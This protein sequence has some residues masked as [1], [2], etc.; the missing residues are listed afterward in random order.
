[1]FWTYIQEW[2]WALLPQVTVRSLEI[3][4]QLRAFANNLDIYT[5]L[6]VIQA[7]SVK[8]ELEAV[9]TSIDKGYK[10]VHKAV[11]ATNTMFQRL[12]MN[13]QGTQVVVLGVREEQGR[14]HNN[15]VTNLLAKLKEW[16]QCIAQLRVNLRHLRKWYDNQLQYQGNFV[17]GLEEQYGKANIQKAIDKTG[18]TANETDTSLDTESL[19]SATAQEEPSQQPSK[20]T[21]DGTNTRT[22]TCT[23]LIESGS[24]STDT[25]G[26]E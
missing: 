12:S 3:Q 23:V 4:N 24:S 16:D 13:I 22:Q 8:Q 9:W 26:S 21:R 2:L 14:Q 17:A 7:D 5:A 6:T 25:T 1:M 20:G 19:A 18:F 15:S 11:H 10:K